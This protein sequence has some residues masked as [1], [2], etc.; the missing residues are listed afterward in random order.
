[1]ASWAHLHGLCLLAS[2]LKGNA[3]DL[4]NHHR[5]FDALGVRTRVYDHRARYCLMELLL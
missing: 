2:V 1:M 4:Q 5:I 3:Q